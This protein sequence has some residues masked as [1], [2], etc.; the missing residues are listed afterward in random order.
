MGEFVKDW[1]WILI[2][3]KV[4]G[5]YRQELWSD[6]GRGTIIRAAAVNEVEQQK[7]RAYGTYLM[8]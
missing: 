5:D 8:G 3:N 2:L 7:S 4:G 6:D 1:V